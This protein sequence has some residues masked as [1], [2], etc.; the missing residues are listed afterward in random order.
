MTDIDKRAKLETNPFSFRVTKDN[1]VFIHW[2]GKQ[3][4]ALKGSAAEKFLAAI[5]GADDQQAQLIMAKATGQF[6]HGNEK[7]A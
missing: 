3:V 5:T 1:K 2:N 4:M 7:R 6:K